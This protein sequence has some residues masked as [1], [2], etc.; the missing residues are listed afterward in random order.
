MDKKDLFVNRLDSLLFVRVDLTRPSNLQ[1]EMPF[2]ITSSRQLVSS[3]NVPTFGSLW[4]S[5]RISLSVCAV[6][7]I[8]APNRCLQISCLNENIYDHIINYWIELK[9]F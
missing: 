5:S 2:L 3:M 4:D 6:P 1:Y 8:M 7:E 9:I